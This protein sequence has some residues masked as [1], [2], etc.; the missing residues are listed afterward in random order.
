MLSKT[1]SVL[2]VSACAL[3][4]LT[5]STVLAGKG[6]YAL[7]PYDQV[8]FVPLDPKNPDGPQIGVV[9]GNPQKGPS[10]FYIKLKPG[11]MPMHSHSADYT[12]VSVKGQTK[13]WVEGTDAEAASLAVGSYWFQPGRQ[14]HGDACI[15]PGECVLFIQ[16][17]GKFDFKPAPQK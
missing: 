7:V 6:K 9:S 8:Q 17:K 3:A 15:G 1:R 2:L 12:A 10:S 14:V 16:M 5:A 13:H 4:L 11:T